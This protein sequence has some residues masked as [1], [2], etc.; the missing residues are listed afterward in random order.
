[1]NKEDF[2]QKFCDDFWKALRIST[3]EFFIDCISYGVK[4]SIK[5]GI[6]EEKSN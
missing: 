5:K 4:M 2:S 3:A 1:M 6:M